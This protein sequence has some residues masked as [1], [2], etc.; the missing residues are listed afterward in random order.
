ML[1]L[2]DFRESQDDVE[3]AEA[4]VG[5]GM[6]GEAYNIFLKLAGWKIKV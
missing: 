4:A 1:D 5:S 3:K 6:A 2:R